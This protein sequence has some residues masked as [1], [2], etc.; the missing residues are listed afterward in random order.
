MA[1]VDADYKFIWIE[2]GTTGCHPDAQVFNNSELKHAIDTGIIDY[3]NA[4]HLPGDDKDVSFS[5]PSNL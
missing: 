5:L 4:A 1:F 2:V 3:P